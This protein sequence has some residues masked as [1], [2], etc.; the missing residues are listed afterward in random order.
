MKMININTRIDRMI[1]KIRAATELN[2]EHPM[3]IVMNPMVSAA[4]VELPFNMKK[5]NPIGS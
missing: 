4:E 1:L 3:K 5:S 2:R